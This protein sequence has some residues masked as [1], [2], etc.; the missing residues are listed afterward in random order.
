MHVYI[1]CFIVPLARFCTN[2]TRTWFQKSTSA[3]I[4]KNKIN[5]QKAEFKRE[6]VIIVRTAVYFLL[7]R[8]DVI[9]NELL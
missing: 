8:R 9:Q 5:K 7:S 2:V 3:Q 1:G 6:T 4:K